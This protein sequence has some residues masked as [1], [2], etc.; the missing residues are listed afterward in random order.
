MKIGLYGLPS[1]GKTTLL[2]Q[3]R[4]APVRNGS[5]LLQ[6]LAPTFAGLPERARRE[7]RR[8]LARTLQAEDGFVMDG[9]Y[10]FGDTVVFT[11]EDGALYDAFLYLYVDPEVLRERMARSEKNR[12]YAALDLARWQRAEIE[13]LRAYCHGH[14][15]DFYVLDDPPQNCFADVTEP[16]SFLRA[17]W[18]GY[19]CVQFARACAAEI[20]AEDVRP[21]VTLTDGDRTL[22]EEDSSSAVFRYRTRLF[23]GNFYTGYQ[24]WRQAKEFHAVEIPAQAALP[25][26][27][28]PKILA[29][30]EP[31]VY[32]LTS[33]HPEIWK[34]FAGQLRF[35]YFC[36]SPMSADTKGFIAKFL[37]Q[38]GRTVTAYGDSL[39]DY[40]M[41]KQADQ[42]YLITRPDGSVS[43][44]L[45]GR[46]LGGITFV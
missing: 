45:K 43:R 7:V 22:T 1:A 35:R 27:F 40:Y 44:S 37:R 25:V 38:A 14:D 19:S 42:G 24:S 9:H 17:V 28:S 36:G 13:A 5:R 18:E 34:R 11:E 10:A 29:R 31:P 26:R 33:G 4:F 21:A 46:D 23:D 16:L 41:L 15:K 8:R 32:I 6:E 20:L 12:T 30:L 2:E 3:I 39:N